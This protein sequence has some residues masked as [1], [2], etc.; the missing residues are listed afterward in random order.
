M[1]SE[2]D[3]TI[4]PNSCE[5]LELVPSQH[6]VFP[7][8]KCGKSSLYDSIPNKNWQ[9]ISDHCIKNICTPVTVFLRDPKKRFIS[10]VNTYLQHIESDFPDLDPKTVLWFVD[11][12]LFLNRHY[13]PQFFWILNLA[14]YLKHDVKLQLRDY[15]DIA[16]LTDVHSRAGISQPSAEFLNAIEHFDW[17]RLEMYFYL[18]Q[19]LT[20][21][22]GQDLCI[23]ELIDLVRCQYPEVYDIVFRPLSD[24]VNNV[25]SPT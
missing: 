17:K 18:D 5:V 16:A 15:R 10:G 25:L 13:A 12:Y 8:F 9:V 7:I 23:K 6:Y 2:I 4:F 20:D 22:I 24:F 21:R 1:L 3:K 19:I 11:N 14:K